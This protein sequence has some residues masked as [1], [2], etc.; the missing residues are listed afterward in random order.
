MDGFVRGLFTYYPENKRQEP[1]LAVDNYS[2]TNIYLGVRASDGAWEASLF[3]RNLFNDSTA[4]DI[5]NIQENLD[6]QLKSFPS[7]IR[8]SGYFQTTTTA[9]REV[10]VSVHYALGSR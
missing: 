8:P 4:T 3:A 5:S 10:G 9:P 6:G 7:L 1:G 2:V